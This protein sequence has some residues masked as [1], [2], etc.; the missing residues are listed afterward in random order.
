MITNNI[1]ISIFSYHWTCSN[2]NKMATAAAAAAG[3]AASDDDDD[4]TRKKK[5][6]EE[7]EEKLLIS[8][9]QDELRKPITDPI[10]E[11]TADYYYQNKDKVAMLLYKY[12]KI[13]LSSVS[14]YIYIYYKKFYFH[15]C[16]Y[17]TKKT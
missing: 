16:A 10:K 11:S 12:Y 1:I 4:L 14:K 17:I 2:K 7:E 6:E 13:L 15:Q 9:I 8:Q 5:A 3:A